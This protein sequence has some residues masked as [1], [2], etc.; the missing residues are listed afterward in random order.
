MTG[1]AVAKLDSTAK[2]G[3]LLSLTR[4][5]EIPIKL[6][7]LGE[8]IEDLQDFSAREFADGIV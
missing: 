6:V 4:E 3:T 8:K 1:I 2:G 5:M 7:G